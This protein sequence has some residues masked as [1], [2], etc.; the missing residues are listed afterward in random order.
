MEKRRIGFI[1]TRF[2]GTDGVS[3]ETAKWDQVLRRE[4]YDCFYMAGELDTPV[5]CSFL[6]PEAH[7]RNKEIWSIHEACFNQTLR[8]PET[9]EAV[10]AMK[11]KIKKQIYAFVDQFK[12]DLLIPENALTIPFNIPLGL[13]ITEFIMESGM[14]MI[15]HHH[16]FYWERSRFLNN[17]CWDYLATAFPPNLFMSEHAV[18]N[19]SQHHQLSLRRGLSTTIV[20]NVMDY[21]NPPPEA[22]DYSLDVREQLGVENDEVFVLQ[23][24]RIITRKGIE[25]AIELVH[26][27]GRPAKL[28]ISHAAGDEGQEYYDRVL[29]Y[30]E[31]LKVNVILC[32]DNVGERRGTLEDGRKVYTLADLY[33]RCDLVTYPSRIEGF[34]NA[35]LEA[36]YYRCPIV[37]NNYSIYKYDIKPK[38]FQTIEMDG[39]VSDETV[40][41][42]QHLLDHP[43]LVTEVTNHNYQLAQR[44][45]SYEVLWSQLNAML[46]KC[47]GAQDCA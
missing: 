6:V 43:S 11:K 3:L 28:V 14:K 32:A 30:A 20:P 26:R 36:I 33:Q 23:P 37:V 15:A 40:R 8:T 31:L 41:S 5:E 1:G 42:A 45:F 29:Q 17:A 19:S 10:E 9:S 44:F 34:G 18:L 35:F 46:T 38:G 2:A 13:A 4:G 12:L 16:D 22:D 25:D 24:T 7:F 39:F 47:F 21:S 27:L